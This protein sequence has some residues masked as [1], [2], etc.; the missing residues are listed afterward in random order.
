[1]AVDDDFLEKWDSDSLIVRTTSAGLL[2][3][4]STDVKTIP[5]AVA[6]VSSG[7]IDII[8]CGLM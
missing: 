3:K 7:H 5:R 1:M 6:G 4:G 2:H 8:A